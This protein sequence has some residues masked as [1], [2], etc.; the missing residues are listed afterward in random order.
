VVA[1]T[2]E[3]L[4]FIDH[5]LAEIYGSV[6]G[7]R[8]LELGDQVIMDAPDLPPTAKAYYEAAG[9]EHIS[10]DLNGLN[11]SLPYDLAKHLPRR[12]WDN[13]FDV[14]TNAGTLEH[15]EPFAAQYTCFETAHRC[16]KV[17]GLAIHLMPDVDELD[18]SGAWKYHCNHYYS[19][20]FFQHLALQHG[21]VVL[22]STLVDWFVDPLRAVALLKVEDRAF[23]PDRADFLSRIARRSGGVIYDGINGTFWTR[24]YHKLYRM[25]HHA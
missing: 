25:L 8:M 23:T 24:A 6:N 19:D 2:R 20:R 16:L 11:G 15:V 14:V 18:R 22:S 5:W 10:I 7:K 13:Y 9:V 21:Y 17:G 4:A 1:L 3:S 12:D